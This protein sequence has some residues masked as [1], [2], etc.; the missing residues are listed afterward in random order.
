MDSIRII[1][2]LFVALCTSNSLPLPES[3]L[4]IEDEDYPEYR[5]G[6]RYDE[7]PV[8]NSFHFQSTKQKTISVIYISMYIIQH[9]IV[10]VY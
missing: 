1:F 4:E 7:Y 6:V 9:S 3:S 8:S 10:T 2:C 5:L